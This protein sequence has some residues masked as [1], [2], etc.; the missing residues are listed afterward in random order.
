M[1]VS[2]IKEQTKE[3]VIVY[4]SVCV[5]VHRTIWNPLK[6]LHFAKIITLSVVQSSSGHKY[7]NIDKEI[8]KKALLFAS[9]TPGITVSLICFKK[10][11][12]KQNKQIKKHKQTKQQLS[13]ATSK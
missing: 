5:C 4:M 9:V 8:T 10:K 11:K 1:H 6:P 7:W 2:S 3:I 12:K 13:F